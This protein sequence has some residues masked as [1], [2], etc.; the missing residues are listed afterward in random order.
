[1]QLNYSLVGRE[2][3]LH[4][5]ACRVNVPLGPPSTTV[6]QSNAMVMANLMPFGETDICS[7]TGSS[8]HQWLDFLHVGLK[9]EAAMTMMFHSSE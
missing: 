6:Q 4:V 8:R 5:S 7:C 3:G 2:G 1:M 9:F